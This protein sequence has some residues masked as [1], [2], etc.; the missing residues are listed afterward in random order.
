MKVPNQKYPAPLS[1]YPCITNFKISSPCH[2]N[3]VPESKATTVP[4]SNIVKKSNFLNVNV[5]KSNKFKQVNHNLISH[6][7]VKNP[8]LCK[9]TIIQPNRPSSK[10]H[11]VLKSDSTI[12]CNKKKKIQ[13]NIIPNAKIRLKL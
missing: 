8:S 3:I 6:R 2:K 1:K 5:V 12:V 4:L 7:R 9:K 13:P 10:P 11:R